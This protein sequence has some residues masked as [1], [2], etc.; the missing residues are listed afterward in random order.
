EAMPKA[1]KEQEPGSPARLQETS[2]LHLAIQCAEF[3]VIEQVLAASVQAEKKPAAALNAR[4]KDGNTPLHLAS[5]LGR[6]PVVRALLDQEGIND[7]ISNLKG[8]TPL[9][10]A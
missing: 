3:P 6:V 2:L 7:A 9:D 8:E 5:R 1:I 10:V 4:D